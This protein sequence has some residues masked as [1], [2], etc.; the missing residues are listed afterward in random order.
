M[1]IEVNK[2]T[3]SWPYWIM[4]FF[5]Q[6][7]G[8]FRAKRSRPLFFRLQG[9]HRSSRDSLLKI[10]TTRS[11]FQSLFFIIISISYGLVSE[12][13]TSKKTPS[14]PINKNNQQN[15]ILMLWHSYCTIFIK[16]LASISLPFTETLSPLKRKAGSSRIYWC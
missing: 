5:T 8:S 3:Y 12:S 7:S 1:V 14:K 13:T 2:G 11:F 16:T 15:Q 6:E 10:T 9:I 4:G